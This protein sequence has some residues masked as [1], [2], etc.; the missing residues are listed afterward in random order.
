MAVRVQEPV[1][2]SSSPVCLA[3]NLGWL[4]DQVQN[5]LAAELAVA[6]EPLGLASRGY[7]VL[8]AA[9]EADRTQIELANLVGLDKTTMTVTVD[10]LEAAGLARRTPLSTDRR[11]KVVTVTPAGAQRVAEAREVI[12]QVQADVLA[13]LPSGQRDALMKGLARLVSEPFSCA[14]PG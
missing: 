1:T 8:A 13:R 2:E 3:G 12:E 6:L 9:T 14:S 7:C 10:R 4:L 11:V 5:T